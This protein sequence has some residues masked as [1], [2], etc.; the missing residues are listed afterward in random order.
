MFSYGV[1][2]QIHYWFV[3][4]PVAEIVYGATRPQ[5]AVPTDGPKFVALMEK[6]TSTE[7]DELSRARQAGDLRKQAEREGQRLRAEA[8]LTEAMLEV[9]RARARLEALRKEKGS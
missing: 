4:H 8:K 2:Q 7:L 6:P 5:G 3:P 9:E 1:V